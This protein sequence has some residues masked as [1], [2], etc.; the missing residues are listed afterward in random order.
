MKRR[1]RAGSEPARAQCRKAA[2]RKSR[3][4]R[5]MVRRRSSSAAR[6]ETKIARLT[7][8][9]DEALSQQAATSE[10]LRVISTS[11]GELESVFQTILTNATRICEAQFGTLFRY[12]SRGFLKACNL[13]RPCWQMTMF[14]GSRL[15][16]SFH[17]E[18]P[19]F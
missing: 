6:Q 7:R 16:H 1:S 3:I 18:V 13:D 4:A 5:K 2:A 17:R 11:P 12:D 9:R 19:T 8:E 14:F 10:V 15:P